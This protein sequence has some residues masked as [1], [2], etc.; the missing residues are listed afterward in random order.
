MS[1]PL[2][3]AVV[4]GGTSTEH[5]V[6]LASGR[7]VISRLQSRFQV[8]GVEISRDGRWLLGLPEEQP[9]LDRRF[10][11]T[12]RNDVSDAKAPSQRME[13]NPWQLPA[14]SDM[15][16]LALHGPGGEDGSIQGLLETIGLPYTGSGVLASAI[17]MDKHMTKQLVAAAG[18]HTPRWYQ[19]HRYHWQSA[20]ET[21][22]QSLHRQLPG[23]C[24]VKAVDLGSSIGTYLA[25]DL[26]A[27]EAAVDQA[28]GFSAACLVEARIVGREFTCPVVGC[29]ALGA[30]RALAITE[31]IPRTEFF[32]YRAKYDSALTEE[33]T[34]AA[35][36]P[37]LAE[38]IRMQTLAIHN[39][40]GCAGVSRSDFIVS[41]DQVFFLE[42]NTI[43]GMTASSIIPRAC[44]ATGM[45]FEQLLEDMIDEALQLRSR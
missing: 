41:G 14:M 44:Q 45:D 40:L 28:L 27:V 34:P 30:A 43:P 18:I 1:Q 9:I 6:S 21:V 10:L 29:Q 33:V 25:E 7:N 20:R 13:I 4:C 3:I 17:A 31:I 23:Q 38:E 26:A 2:R 32:D 12:P 11:E 37:Q 5:S 39:L 19:V 22:L 24:F 8:T 15:V 35:I 42:I 36:S 16:F